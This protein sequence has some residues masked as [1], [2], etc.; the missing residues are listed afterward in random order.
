MKLP[1]VRFTTRCFMLIII[2]V[3]V[4]LWRVHEWQKRPYYNQQ[5]LF[6]G[7]M[8]ILCESQAKEWERRAGLCRERARSHVRWDDPSEGVENLKWCPYPNDRPSRD[9]WAELAEVWDRAVI[10]SREA[11]ESYG[12]MH[13]YWDGW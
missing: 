3:S 8:V 9:S 1:R 7:N 5:S 11:A 10:K 6:Y 12:R 4:I 2:L 13:R